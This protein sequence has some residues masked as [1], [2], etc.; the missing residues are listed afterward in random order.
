VAPL[1]EEIKE[2]AAMLHYLRIK[3]ERKPFK[4]QKVEELK[5]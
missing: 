1:L 3:V 5:S 2:L 4:S